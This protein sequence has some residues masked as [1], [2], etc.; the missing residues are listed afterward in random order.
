M[1]TLVPRAKPP[2]ADETIE[3]DDVDLDS[4]IEAVEQRART[5]GRQND[6]SSPDLDKA[7]Q[8]NY[9]VAPGPEWKEGK[10]LPEGWEEMTSAQKATQLWMGDRGLLFWSN[11]AAYASLFIIGGLWVVFRFVGPALGLYDL[12]GGPPQQ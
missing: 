3:K 11:K 6:F 5:R 12:S 10:L 4:G 8:D 2:K 7:V 1:C 9:G